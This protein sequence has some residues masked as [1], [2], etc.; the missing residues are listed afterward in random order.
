[1]YTQCIA[2]T[3]RMKIFLLKT[4]DLYKVYWFEERYHYDELNVEKYYNEHN[5][6]FTTA[7]GLYIFLNLLIS[8]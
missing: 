1:M 7:K 6:E 3:K 5:N 2:S 8:P 4:K